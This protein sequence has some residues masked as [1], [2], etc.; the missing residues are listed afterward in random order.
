MADLI[1]SLGMD[2]SEAEKAAAA[3]HAAEKRRIDKLLSD[4]EVAEKARAEF[5]RRANQQKIADAAKAQKTEIELA[6]EQAKAQAESAK[7]AAREQANAAKEAAKAA[8]EAAAERTRAEKEAERVVRDA[9]RE[10]AKAAREAAAEQARLDN[11]NLTEAEI[12]EKAKAGIYR[13]TNQQRIEEYVKA[14]K[15]ELDLGRESSAAMMSAKNVL[16]SFA[17]QMMGLSGVSSVIGEVSAG[18]QRMRDSIINSTDMM[19]E[20]RETLLELAALKDRMGDTSAEAVDVLRMQAQT[21]QKRSDVI[22]LQSSMLGIG[23]AAVRSGKTTMDD[24]RE[25]M[26]GIGRLQAAQG[27]DAGAYGNLGGL[28]LQT[29]PAQS[30]PE[31]IVREAAAMYDIAQPG[32]FTSFGSA[33]SQ[34]GK[35]MP[36]IQSGV[37]SGREAMAMTSAFSIAEPDQAA[38]RVDQLVRGTIGAMGRD[39][40]VNAPEGTDT[41]GTATYLA[42]LGAKGNMTPVEIAR[43]I[44]EDVK[45]AQ[46]AGGDDFNAFTYLQHQGYGNVED[47]KAILGMTGLID[48]GTWDKTF[49]GAID[50]PNLGKDRIADANRGLANDPGLRARQAQAAAQTADMVASMGR[51]E[52]MRSL[53]AAA[54]AS[55]GGRQAL[56]GYELKD[57]ES[58]SYLSW[59]NMVYGTKQ[60]IDDETKRILMEF[61]DREGVKYQGS[62]GEGGESGGTRYYMSDAEQ[63]RVLGELGQRGINIPSEVMKGLVDAAA[64]MNQAAQNMNRMAA[65][66]PLQAAP[67]RPPAAPR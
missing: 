42:G 23:E 47:L 7:Q 49:A 62:T 18:F 57:I 30:K 37:L 29:M 40:R 55:L 31:D 45:R 56:G 65:P 64:N 12:R 66:Q 6:K 41:Q 59:G 32:G 44:G 21:G 33:A 53:R 54:Y 19:R 52:D 24:V 61:A 58:S 11:R 2:K 16:M 63:T 39:R 27:A 5:I 9:M 50:D 35:A 51:P 3:F 26:V 34:F 25:A 13:K 43:L 4:A 28:L 48:S 22:S 46:A 67:R 36:F 60:R 20:F 17:G 1:I 15:T 14:H 8:K 10:Q 38:T